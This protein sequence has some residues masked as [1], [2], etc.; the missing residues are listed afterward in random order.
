M[1]FSVSTSNLIK[2]MEFQ[3]A[4]EIALLSSKIVHCVTCLIRMCAV[5]VAKPKNFM[6]ITYSIIGNAY[7]IGVVPLYL[8]LYNVILML[9]CCIIVFK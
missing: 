3:V 8:V 2:C 9:P 6:Q 5:I 4:T 1:I 7:I